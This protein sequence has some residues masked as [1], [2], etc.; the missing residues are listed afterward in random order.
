MHRERKKISL[1]IKFT[2][3]Y[4]GNQFHTKPPQLGPGALPRNCL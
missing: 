4:R 3:L 2:R 1:T